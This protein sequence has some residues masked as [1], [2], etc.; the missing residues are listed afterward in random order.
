MKKRLAGI[1][2]TLFLVSLLS[3]CCIN[4]DWQDATC[5][6][7]KTC[8]KCG[9]AEGA[10][11]GHIWTEATCTAAK[12]CSYCG[13]IDGE[14]LGHTWEEWGTTREATITEI[15]LRSRTCSECGETDEESFELEVLHK[16]G[17]FLMTP[18]EIGARLSDKLVCQT[19]QMYYNANGLYCGLKGEAKVGSYDTGYEDGEPIAVVQFVSNDSIMGID[20]KDSASVNG[21]STKFFTTDSDKIVDSMLGLLMACDGSLDD[22]AARK[23]GKEIVAA[24]QN[25]SINHQHNGINYVFTQK[26]DYY[27]F[28]I[29]VI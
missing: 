22:S 25:G 3:A 14:A 12:T 21:L 18:N 16:D 28:I 17:Y 2:V 6:A 27:L 19:A 9:E 20:E 11:L 1:T 7:P 4:H 15:G 13:Q 5:I 26:S 24:F 29:S 10:A 8:V 23:V